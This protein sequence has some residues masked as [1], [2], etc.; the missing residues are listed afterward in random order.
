MAED[1]ALF[2]GLSSCHFYDA[3]SPIVEG[4]SI[5]LSLAFKASR[6]DKGD[7]DYI[8]CP[9]NKEEYLSFRE[10]LL[11]AEQVSLKDFDKKTAKFDKYMLEDEVVDL[12]KY[13]LAPMPGKI[14]SVNVKDEWYHF[15]GHRW[16]RTLEG[17]ILKT[18]I[19]NDIYKLYNEYENK[20][21]E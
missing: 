11:N 10:A 16:E 15:N 14:V 21:N 19:H 5:D 13:L 7:A 9:M 8:N 6:Y 3:A 20:K 17:T 4:E 18:R 2:T 1:I 12:S